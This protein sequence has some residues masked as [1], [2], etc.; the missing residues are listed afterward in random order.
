MRRHRKQPMGTGFKIIAKKF[1]ISQPKLEDRVIKTT[2]RALFPKHDSYRHTIT[3]TNQ[4]TE[5]FTYIT[6]DKILEVA[7]K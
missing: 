7:K 2:L 6:K 3:E 5:N 4:D 1:K